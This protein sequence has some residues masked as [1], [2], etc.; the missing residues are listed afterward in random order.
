M[1][2]DFR[3]FRSD[4]SARVLGIGILIAILFVAGCTTSGNG[5]AQLAVATLAGGL[6]AGS[7][8]VGG[9]AYPPTTITATGG[10]APYAF[11]LTSGS[12]PTGLALS[13][14]GTISGSPTTA[15]P[16]TF[17][18]TVTDSATMKHTASATVYPTTAL[19]ETGGVGPFT[20]ALNSPP[21]SLPG[22]LTLSSAGSISGTISASAVPSTF[23]FVAKVTDSQGNVVVSGTISIKVDAGLAITPPTFPTGVVG[24]TFTSPA[25][26]ASGGSASGFTFAVA[27]GSVAPLAINASNGV[28]TGTPTTAGTLQF[29]VKATDSLGYSV[30]SSNLSITINAAISVALSP[31]SPVTLDQGKTQL[32]TATVSNDPNSAGV[33]WSA[34]TGLGSLTGQTT[35]SATYNAPASVTVAS[36]ATFTATSITDP[37]KSA[38]Y[39]V[40]LVPP[41]QITTTV[42]AAGN[43]NGAYSSPVSMTG[44]VAPYAWAIQAAPVG[45]VLNGSTTST[46][47]VQGTPTVSGNN[48]TFTIKVTDAQGLSTTSNGL[49]ISIYATLVLTP[50]SLP[51]PTGVVGVNYPTSETFTASGGSG[52]GYSWSIVAGNPLPTGLALSLA[53]GTSTSITAGPP[54]VAGTYP[55]AVKLTDSV[56]NT[57]TTSGLSI[58]IN[59]PISIT[60]S[61]TQP[62]AMD[63]NTTQLITATVNND[64]NNAGVSWSTLTGLGSLSGQTSTTVTYSAPATVTSSSI[65]TFTATSVTDP[66]K[67]ASFSISLEPPPVIATPSFPSGTV[68]SSYSSPVTVN[69]GVGPYTWT[70]TA[71][72]AGLSLSSSTTNTVNVT[73]TP[74]TAGANQTVTIKVTDAKGL[75]NTLNS[76]ITITA[77]S[78]STNC[79]ISGTVPDRR[80]RV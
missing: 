14:T 54:T 32:I 27:S 61:P 15:G 59:P 63:Q 45:L 56:G 47:T 42:M 34:V 43:V 4:V 2:R 70:F 50:P 5:E 1:I 49:T 68:G 23:N 72:P 26:I 9:G 46:V 76:T 40:H 28:I 60:L 33:T 78:C 44:G 8:S 53:A 36:N 67:S 7:V 20:F 37:T 73:G 65:A 79:T 24:V 10:T 58:T 12:L 77:P 74:T 80:C 52:T 57:A 55:F 38:I 41:P 29:T 19:S 6:P 22:G 16:F 69:G 71:L 75:T 3:L 62:F 13:A 64:P 66:S 31:A 17:T 48:Q 39:T 35:T 11:A 30:T 51:L 25:F 18:V 21:N